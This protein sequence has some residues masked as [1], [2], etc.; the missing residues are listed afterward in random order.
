MRISLPINSVWSYSKTGIPYL[1]PEIVLLF[2]AKN[3]R[4]KDHLDFIAIND[5]L[6]AE[7]KH[8]LRTVLE[9]HEPGHKWIK[10]LF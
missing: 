10:S 6:D 7:K 8:W 5:Y 2:K 1:N 3:T 9:T 4:D